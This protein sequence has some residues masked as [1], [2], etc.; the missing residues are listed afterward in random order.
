M[1]SSEVWHRSAVPEAKQKITAQMAGI[2]LVSPA[3]PRSQDIRQNLQGFQN[4]L[5]THWDT[6]ELTEAQRG[7]LVCSRSHSKLAW[8]L[9]AGTD[10][11]P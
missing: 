10:A 8:K 3:S 2:G 9:G 11:W 1:V 6:D 5:R 7:R 4:T